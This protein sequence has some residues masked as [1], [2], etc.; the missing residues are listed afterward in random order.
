MKDNT[1]VQDMANG[2]NF[3]WAKTVQ[4]LLILSAF[5]EPKAKCAILTFVFRN[6]NVKLVGHTIIVISLRSINII[7]IFTTPIND[8]TTPTTRGSQ[9][10]Q[11]QQQQQQRYNILMSKTCLCKEWEEQQQSY[12][13]SSSLRLFLICSSSCCSAFSFSRRCFSSRAFCCS[14]YSCCL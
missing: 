4:H 3:H 1:L 13:L 9:Q 11:Q 8:T 14:R 10:Q 2:I 5:P 6:I 12:L 7:E